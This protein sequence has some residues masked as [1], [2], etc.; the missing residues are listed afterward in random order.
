[1]SKVL[2]SFSTE[3]QDVGKAPSYFAYNE[4][5]CSI[6]ARVLNPDQEREI[7][8]AIVQRERLT[9]KA[10]AARYGLTLH[11]VGWHIR[12]IRSRLA[13]KLPQNM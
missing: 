7:L 4:L 10:L 11:Q 5:R 12:K 3:G 6:A 1:M 8:E 13:D 2:A 9:N